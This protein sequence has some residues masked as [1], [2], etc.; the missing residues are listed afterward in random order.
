MEGI[1]T[2]MHK[3][4]YQ[5]R[6]AKKKQHV[7]CYSSDSSVA[8]YMDVKLVDQSFFWHSTGFGLVLLYDVLCLSYG[9]G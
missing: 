6:T 2:R 4:L 1:V 9:D 3:Q 5:E 8:Y 7:P